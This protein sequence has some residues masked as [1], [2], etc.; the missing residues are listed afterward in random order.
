M[1]SNASSLTNAKS[2]PRVEKAICKTKT[3]IRTVSL[4]VRFF[5]VY[6]H[7]LMHSLVVS[8]LPISDIGVNLD[9][10]HLTI[11]RI[12]TFYNKSRAY[13]H[14]FCVLSAFLPSP[15]RGEGGRRPD[16]ECLLPILYNR[17]LYVWRHHFVVI[18][19]HC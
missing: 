4:T 12:T 10:H 2:P 11:Y 14:D 18:E 1:C 5:I 16:E 19:F 9:I 7:L 17:F 3:F 15:C 6:V 8:M 13:W